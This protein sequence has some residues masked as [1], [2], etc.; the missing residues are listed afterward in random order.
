MSLNM[1]RVQVKFLRANGLPSGKAYTYD[2]NTGASNWSVGGVVKADRLSV[3]DRVIVENQFGSDAEKEV[4]VVALGSEFGGEADMILRRSGPTPQD[5][6][7][8]LAR[9]ARNL[10]ITLSTG[11]VKIAQ[12]QVDRLREDLFDHRNKYGR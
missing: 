6:L 8:E 12:G 5:N 10:V 7:D 9:L 4:E 1:Q 11:N 3:G 2:W